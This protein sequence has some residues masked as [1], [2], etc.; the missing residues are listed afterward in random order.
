MNKND[1]E[2]VC[3]ALLNG[4]ELL[5]ETNPDK[6][7]AYGFVPGM[8]HGNLA[9]IYSA[10]SQ[11]IGEGLFMFLT[12]G[13]FSTGKSTLINTILNE[14]VLATKITPA[15]G[16]IALLENGEPGSV[17]VYYENDEHGNTR[18]PKELSEKDFFVQYTLT[19]EDAE[20]CEKTGS[21]QRFK[22][23]MYAVIRRR[24]ALIEDGVRLVDSPGLN[25]SISQN[26][27]TE[28]FLP[29]ANAV[30]FV[31]S[32]LGAFHL[33]ERM[34]IDKNFSG[35]YPQNVFFVF[36]RVDNTSYDQLELLKLQVRK[37]LD[38]VFRRPDGSFDDALFAD[39]VFY[40]DAYHSG[41]LRIEGKAYNVDHKGVLIPLP[42]LTLEDTEIPRFE[43]AVKTFLASDE[44]A[45]GQYRSV[46]G[47]V[48]GA[49]LGAQ[50]ASRTAYEM[51]L[52]PLDELD[53]NI[54]S[55]TAELDKA[56]INLESIRRTFRSYAEILYN[57]L[58]GNMRK[59]QGDIDTDWLE[60]AEKAPQLGRFE[61]IGRGLGGIIHA[62]PI[63]ASQ[64]F[65]KKKM[66][67]SFSTYT[68][69][70][71]PF[72]DAH[73][74]ELKTSN[75]SSVESVCS[76]LQRALG[77][78]LDMIAHLV[79]SADDLFRGSRRTR[80]MK[81]MNA[82]DVF[83]TLIN[84][85]NVDPAEAA[86]AANGQQS[87]GDFFTSMT[88]NTV[89]KLG[90]LLVAGPFAPAVLVG[91]IL[92]HIFNLGRAGKKMAETDMGMVKQGFDENMKHEFAK[93][94]NQLP[95]MILSSFKPA[96]DALINAITRE[97]D[98]IKNR[99]GK[100][101][102]D[103]Q[104]VGFNAE[105]RKKVD[106]RNLAALKECLNTINTTLFAKEL[107]ED[108]IEEA[109]KYALKSADAEK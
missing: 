37:G 82:G 3:G 58:D 90:I 42:D 16:V 89:A 86:M 61:V 13:E 39:R 36:T 108:G 51:S 56:E 34:Y 68:D 9:T 27:T 20:E 63:D 62:I 92:L 107:T 81:G 46:M 94:K 10:L 25:E 106:D 23:V 17:K 2:R 109:A 105:E 87:W 64:E 84:I 65:I 41:Q 67:A 30:I 21:I 47:Q 5:G 77:M 29:K 83:K 60:H 85:V 66:E 31:M 101:L 11:Q 26:K 22:N 71:Q 38:K 48:A 79:D 99:M 102:A 73:L 57:K 75:A 95:Q 100:A 78:Q 88:T 33:G 55:A 69:H 40:V 1:V 76:E 8:G 103:R 52:M 96:E 4:A 93:Q 15:T 54:A 14:N 80:D 97:I 53:A 72:F 24:C 43:R 45:V 70:A 98:A 28:R 50:R 6:A 19:P 7:A 35:K 59:V 49:Y 18:P 44:K 32:A 91:L 104:T 12:M 74:A